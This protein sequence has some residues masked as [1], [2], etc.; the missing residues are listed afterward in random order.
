MYQASLSQAN[1][2]SLNYQEDN[3]KEPL[4]NRYD[5]QF[6][7]ASISTMNES[8]PQGSGGYQ[9][10]DIESAFKIKPFNTGEISEEHKISPTSVINDEDL[11]TELQDPLQ[12]ESPKGIAWIYYSFCAAILLALCNTI[13]SDLSAIGLE[14][15][16]YL[17][18]GNIIC[19][20]MYCSVQHMI[21]SFKA[22]E[23]KILP[24]VSKIK[25][26]S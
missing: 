22:P 4:L 1:F 24:G 7:N 20:L 19:G 16:L 6:Q 15:L 23:A 9:Q 3:L 26:M 13:M 11:K 10:K 12:H 2:N 17:S 14:G 21:N 5:S 8:P 18:P 25:T